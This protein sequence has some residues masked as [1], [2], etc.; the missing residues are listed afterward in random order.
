ME[1]TLWNFIWKKDVLRGIIIST[2]ILQLYAV[3]ENDNLRG[4]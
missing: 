1:N 3:S 4:E 2:L